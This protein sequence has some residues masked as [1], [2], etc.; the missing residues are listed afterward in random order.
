MLACAVSLAILTSS[1]AQADDEARRE[2]YEVGIQHTI[3]AEELVGRQARRLQLRVRLTNDDVRDLF[4]LRVRLI[5]AGDAGWPL[6]CSRKPALLR[7]LPSGETKE[8]VW[9]FVCAG[10]P[11]SFAASLQDLE[12]EIEAVE[13]STQA[14]VTFERPSHGAG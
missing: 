6:S 1:V 10:W 9:D 11:P 2:P 13:A 7:A 5:E 14:I 3:L 8:V 4:D 12:F